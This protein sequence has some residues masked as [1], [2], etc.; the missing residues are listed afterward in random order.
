MIFTAKH[1]KKSLT[2]SL[3]LLHNHAAITIR[4]I[5]KFHPPW[6]LQ[7]TADPIGDYISDLHSLTLSAA[8]RY[9]TICYSVMQTALLL[10]FHCNSSTLLAL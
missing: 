3:Y 5:L 9:E 2:K 4:Q 7:M 6:L 8:C 1:Q 10:L